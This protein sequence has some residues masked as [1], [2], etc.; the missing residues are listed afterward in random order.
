MELF[1]FGKGFGTR[2]IERGLAQELGG[3]AKIEYRPT[4]IWCEINAHISG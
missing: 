1:Q 3:E 2:L 4:G